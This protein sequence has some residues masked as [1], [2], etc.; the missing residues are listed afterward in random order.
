MRVCHTLFDYVLNY[1]YIM[2][3]SLFLHFK[4]IFSLFFILFILCLLR[5]SPSEKHTYNGLP[6]LM[7][8]VAKSELQNLD[9]SV[10]ECNVIYLPQVCM[11]CTYDITEIVVHVLI[12]LSDVHVHT[13]TAAWKIIGTKST[14]IHLQIMT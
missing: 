1:F 2:L 10:S 3:L 9:E 6:E 13:C 12:L 14:C 7:T 11:Y 5:P 8:R 4:Y